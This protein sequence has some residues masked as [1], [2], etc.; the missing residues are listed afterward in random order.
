MLPPSV[1]PA[2][3]SYPSADRPV[4][5]FILSL[6]GGLLIIV[7]GGF[8]LLFF[9]NGYYYGSSYYGSNLAFVMVAVTTG[10]VVLAGCAML[11]LRPDQH[12]IWG[13]IVVVFSVMSIFSWVGGL[14]GG[15]F[16]GMVLGIIGG[17]LAIAW[18]PGGTYGGAPRTVRFCT[19]CGRYVAFGYPYCGFC[20][21]PA[22][23]WRPP[24]A[25]PEQRPP[26]APP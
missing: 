11:Y 22:P 24:M 6:L 18:N 5:P 17:C 16:V 19:G 15:F 12:V 1:S 2:S 10:I 9:N 14:F 4:T 7:A 13:V 26:V 8:G 25:A 20:G 21:T 23:V 3:A